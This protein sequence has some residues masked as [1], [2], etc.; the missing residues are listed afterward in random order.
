MWACKDT[1]IQPVTLDKVTLSGEWRYVGKLSHNAYLKCTICPEFD[2]E[3]SI[4]RITFKED[5]TFEARINLLITKGN[6]VGK[7]DAN[8][9]STYYYGDIDI[10]NFQVLNKPFETEEDGN[11]QRYF[12]DTKRFGQT[13]KANNVFEYDELQLSLKNT[14]SSEFLLFARKK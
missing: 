9:T 11:F 13:T 4:Y 6:Y 10:T 5:G 1:D 12:L 2:Y 7:P 3:K 8:S 14:D